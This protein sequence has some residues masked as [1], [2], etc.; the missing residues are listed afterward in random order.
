MNK[1]KTLWLVA[2]G[3]LASTI[4]YAQSRAFHVAED[5]GSRAMFTSDAPLETIN[6][7]TSHVSGDLQVDPTHLAQ[8]RGTIEVQVGTI[9]TGIDLRDEHLRSESW[10]DAGRFPTARFEL[11]NVTGATTLTP[12]QEAR[13]TLQ[14]HF[15][16]HGR[17][18]DVRATGRVTWVADASGAGTNQIRVRAHFGIR[19]TDYGISIPS[20]VELKVSNEIAVDVSLRATVR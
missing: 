11:T 18:H 4:A 12:G 3:M 8:S 2:L 16:L 15:T 1:T 5:G 13:L 20:I 17:T 19:L 9:H 6:G 14:G 7:V 10:L